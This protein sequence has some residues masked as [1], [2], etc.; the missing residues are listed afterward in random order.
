M[1]GNVYVFLGPP[2]AGKGTQAE[3][4]ANKLKADYFSLGEYFRQQIKMKT[5]LGM[6]V[7]D[8]LDRGELVPNVDKIVIP[9]F[10]KNKDKDFVLDGFPRNMRQEQEIFQILS[11]KFSL[12]LVAVFYLKVSDKEIIKRLSG[13]RYCPDCGKQY[14][15]TY[16]KPRKDNRCD[17]CNAELAWRSDDEPQVIRERL[18]EYKKETQPLVQHYKEQSKLIEINGEQ[19]IAA[20]HKQIMSKI[21]A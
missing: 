3:M 14:H 5:P 10:R 19:G 18:K 16:K 7:K 9:F 20:I 6:Q 2:G 17:S 1:A 11:K 15:M 8:I 21:K 13:R 12:K 4:V